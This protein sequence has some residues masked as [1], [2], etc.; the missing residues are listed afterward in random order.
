ME[1]AKD[2]ED[3]IKETKDNSESEYEDFVTCGINTVDP[4]VSGLL[5]TVF[6]FILRR[7]RDRLK[8]LNC[9]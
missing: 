1:V 9:D 7:K 4:L 5:S 3:Q 8:Q 2:D 6:D